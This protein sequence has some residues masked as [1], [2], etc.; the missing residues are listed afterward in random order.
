[1]HCSKCES[2]RFLSDS[3][4][5]D[6][7]HYH[8]APM[9]IKAC[10][11][12]VPDFGNI[13]NDLPEVEVFTGV[14]KNTLRYKR[15]VVDK[16]NNREYGYWWV[17]LDN[18]ETTREISLQSESELEDSLNK[19]D[20]VTIYCP[21]S[22]VLTY[23]VQNGLEDTITNDDFAS[24]VVKHGMDGQQSSLRRTYE[25]DGLE[26]GYILK[27]SFIISLFILVVGGYGLLHLRMLFSVEAYAMAGAV[28]WGGISYLRMRK[29]QARFDKQDEYY[30]MIRRYLT[31]IR[32]T[33]IYQLEGTQI[34]RP[35]SVDDS[36]CGKCEARIDNQTQYCCHCGHEQVSAT[37]SIDTQRCE[38]ELSDTSDGLIVIKHGEGLVAPQR[39][40]LKSQLL[41]QIA[42]VIEQV[43]SDYTHE[44]AVGSSLTGNMVSDV[45]L[46]TV[47]HRD[48]SS[49]INSWRTENVQKTT[50]TNRYGH[51]RTET[52]VLSR[53]DHRR[54]NL[55]G[56]VVI[57]TIDGDEVAYNPGSNQLSNTDVGD[58]VVVARSLLKLDKAGEHDYQQF[59]YNLSKNLYWDK[60]CI[61][62]F[63]LGGM[64]GWVVSLLLIATVAAF[65]FEP[66]LAVISGTFV[67]FIVFAAHSAQKKNRAARVTFA[68]SFASKLNLVHQHG[69]SWVK[70]LG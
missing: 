39:K 3:Y 36:L 54:S 70:M 9:L 32:E 48:L 69:K 55:N 16:E 67:S 31:L 23:Q 50:Y 7:G 46:G 43:E 65:F 66:V 61:S 63:S 30:Q 13:Q 11:D 45:I 52:K 21:T 34:K 49:N 58:H 6:C 44:F 38:G 19:G 2:A 68:E 47:I 27:T 62:S 42:P 26:T 8:E 33:T 10:K 41:D 56:Y 59:Y 24:A 53:K 60:E 4:C 5:P 64:T 37:L 57:Q 40:S 35:R 17:T 28:L 20:I 25:P 22:R 14:V 51:S 15:V 18:G 12:I 29:D 1:M